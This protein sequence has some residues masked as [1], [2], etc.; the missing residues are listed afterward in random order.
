[1]LGQTVFKFRTEF[2]IVSSDL[3]AFQECLIE[4]RLSR[5]MH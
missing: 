2:L 4:H 3:C 5:I 1:M